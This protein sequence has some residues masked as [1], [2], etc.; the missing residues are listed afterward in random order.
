VAAPSLR[1]GVVKSYKH[2]KGW[3]T[4]ITRLRELGRV[5]ESPDTATLFQ[6][7]EAGRIDAFP[8][9]PLV[10]LAFENRYGV[11]MPLQRLHWFPE[12]PKIEHALILSKTRLEPGTVELFGK[13]INAMREDGTLLRIYSRYL[14][15]ADA[16]VLLLP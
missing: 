6:R 12:D 3:D 14:P 8:A 5:D 16:R 4:W 7:L 10:T 9:L 15:E 2:G 1:L 13:A 11:H